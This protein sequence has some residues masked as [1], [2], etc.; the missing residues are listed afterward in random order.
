L[1]IFLICLIPFIIA[2]SCD[3]PVAPPSSPPPDNISTA[4]FKKLMFDGYAE[5]KNL[6]SYFPTSSGANKDI[7]L[8]GTK[9]AQYTLCGENISNIE[10]IVTNEELVF[11]YRKNNPNLNITLNSFMA[12]V[13]DDQEN[14]ENEPSVQSGS[15]NNL[16]G[17]GLEKIQKIAAR[18]KLVK[19]HLSSAIGS[20]LQGVGAQFGNG[21]NFNPIGLGGVIDRNVLR[22]GKDK[23]ANELAMVEA[24]SLYL[25]MHEGHKLVDQKANRTYYF[26]DTGNAINAMNELIRHAGFLLKYHSAFAKVYADRA[27]CIENKIFK[28][29]D[30]SGKTILDHLKTKSLDIV[31]TKNNEIDVFDSVI[32]SNEYIPGE[33][34]SSCNFSLDTPGQ[35]I[36][37]SINPNLQGPTASSVFENFSPQN[38]GLAL[39]NKKSFKQKLKT[40]G[41]LVTK[42]NTIN[43]TDSTSGVGSSTSSSLSDRISN[44]QSVTA[45]FNNKVKA[46]FKKLREAKVKRNSIHK[47][48]PKGSS[49]SAQDFI[50]REGQ[51]A[52]T[53]KTLESGLIASINSTKNS[54]LSGRKS[55]SKKEDSKKDKFNSLKPKKKKGSKIFKSKKI[56]SKKRRKPKT[57]NKF[58]KMIKNMKKKKGFYTPL[59]RD[60]LF[61]IISKAYI[62]E[63]LSRLNE[64]VGVNKNNLPTR[65]KKYLNSESD[66]LFENVE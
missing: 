64:E 53:L 47:S 2:G 58:S 4:N 49:S 11:L 39:D 43:S 36:G 19:S 40:R 57:K 54:K 66:D 7:S 13:D 37:P 18:K 1:R 8:F 56:V 10:D 55:I 5:Y 46:V 23:K 28:K 61:S 25:K 16:S 50:S 6:P 31:G 33:T 60:S 34:E 3:S 24:M 59:D 45:D 35:N 17:A 9:G 26:R 51:K 22:N 62:R 12:Q 15:N 27:A 41:K 65:G 38:E 29:V 44:A 21:E 48:I 20:E 14:D 30:A 52:H 63:G 42:Q 32:G